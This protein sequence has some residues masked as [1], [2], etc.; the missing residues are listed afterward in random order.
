MEATQM[1][2]SAWMNKPNTMYICTLEYYKTL[3]EWGTDVCHIVDKCWTHAEWKKP[4]TKGDMMS[5]CSYME[6]TKICESIEPKTRC[7]VSWDWRKEWIET[8]CFMVKCLSWRWLECS[9]A[10]SVTSALWLCEHAHCYMHA[11]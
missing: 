3:T 9:G 8:G 5:D 1:S 4:D 11:F 7:M 10:R 6:Y 2:I